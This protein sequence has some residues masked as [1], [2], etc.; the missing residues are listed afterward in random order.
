[1][2]QKLELSD[3]ILWKINQLKTEWDKTERYLKTAEQLNGE[4]IYPSIMELRYS[5]RRIIDAIHSLSSQQ[6]SAALE[7]LQDALFDCHR[8]RHDAI[9]VGVAKIA[10]DL[11]AASET[12]G[13]EVIIKVFPEF[14]DLRAAIF[15]TQQKIAKSRE[16][17]GNRDAIYDAL[18]NEDFDRIT[19]LYRD[20]LSKQSVIE[21]LAGERSA[22]QA[23]D[24]RLAV[25]GIVVGVVGVA[26]GFLFG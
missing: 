5:G 12:L 21:E 20:F 23:R 16:H 9:D 7:M 11:T 24:R 10:I 3:E 22:A 26:A 8:A 17:R 19:K 13:L 25:I 4:V 2:S 15:T 14:P 18:E 1:V 6:E